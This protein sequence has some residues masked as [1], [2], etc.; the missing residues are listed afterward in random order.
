MKKLNVSNLVYPCQICV[1]KRLG[2]G[3]R[4]RRP[5][6]GAHQFSPDLAA[7]WIWSCANKISSK[8][9]D[10]FKKFEFFFL[11]KSKFSKCDKL[12]FV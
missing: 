7:H 3:W 5:C 6:S 8:L 12:I 4:C 11:Q 2:V 10:F 9:P 1:S